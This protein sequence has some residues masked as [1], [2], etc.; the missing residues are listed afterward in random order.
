MGFDTQLAWFLLTQK[1]PF[2]GLTPSLVSTSDP[3]NQDS[4]IDDG[5]NRYEAAPIPPSS[6]ENASADSPAASTR[7]KLTTRQYAQHRL[8]VWRMAYS[9]WRMR[10][11]LK[12]K[13]KVTH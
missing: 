7:N 2:A 9:K 13:L 5:G 11:I 6:P 12:S 4:T 10:Q 3:D 1:V 8:N